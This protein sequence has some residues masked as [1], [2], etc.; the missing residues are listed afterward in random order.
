MN[1]SIT[2]VMGMPLNVRRSGHLGCNVSRFNSLGPINH[3]FEDTI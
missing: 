2:D 1:D 3:L